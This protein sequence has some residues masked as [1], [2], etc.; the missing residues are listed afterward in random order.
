MKKKRKRFS[1]KEKEVIENLYLKKELSSYKIAEFLNR[2]PNSIRCYLRNLGIARKHKG[3][4]IEDKLARFLRNSGNY[5]TQQSGI[6]PYD[7]LMDGERIDVKSSHKVIVNKGKPWQAYKFQ[8]QDLK[9]RKELKD[10]H[11]CVDWFYLVFL[12]KLSQ[13][14]RVFRLA[15]SNVNKHQQTLSVSNPN[16]RKHIEFMGFLNLT[17]GGEIK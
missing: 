12:S 13:Q 17:E 11:Q 7:L 4:V 1:K 16:E 10:L 3:R 6:A 5:V 15:S 14:A 2:K 9:S 8:L